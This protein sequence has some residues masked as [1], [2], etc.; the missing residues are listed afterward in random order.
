MVKKPLRNALVGTT[1][2]AALLLPAFTTVAPQIELSACAYPNSIVTQ[3]NISA[4][5]VIQDHTT[6]TAT[7]DVDTGVAPPQ[8]RVRFKVQGKKKV[9]AQYD[10]TPVQFSFGGA[11]KAGRNYKLKAKFFG[12]C[13]FR[14]SSD[15]MI[16]TVVK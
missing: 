2:G 3:T 7:V 6:N 9:W 14:N 16:V 15:Q 8:G 1:A 13:R 4:P 10:G 12:N 5:A 11:F